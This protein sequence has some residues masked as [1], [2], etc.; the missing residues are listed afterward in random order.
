MT[1]R[2]K[3]LLAAELQEERAVPDRRS[4]LRIPRTGS[5]SEQRKRPGAIA[6]GRLPDRAGRAWSGSFLGLSPS[7]T[8]RDAVL[9]LRRPSFQ[10]RPG[11][12]CHSCTSPTSKMRGG[13]SNCPQNASAGRR[14]RGGW[15]QVDGALRPIV[16]RGQT[17]SGGKQ[18]SRL[19]RTK[20]AM[21]RQ[22]QP[23]DR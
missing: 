18:E 14:L 19:F 7:A 23:R 20:L 4:R 10:P 12:Y 3:E 17:R 11:V 5:G 22:L 16:A 8:S 1:R 2:M 15:R 9:D 13:T 6:N 21:A